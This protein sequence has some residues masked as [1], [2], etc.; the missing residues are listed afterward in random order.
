MKAPKDPAKTLAIAALCLALLGFS[1]ALLG[2]LSGCSWASTEELYETQPNT[3]SITG[4]GR[5]TLVVRTV[6]DDGSVTI[7]T[8]EK[9]TPQ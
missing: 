9:E 1:L 7:E 5:E 2:F 6:H 8:Y 3:T 4:P